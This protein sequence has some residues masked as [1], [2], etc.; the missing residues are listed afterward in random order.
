MGCTQ[1]QPQAPVYGASELSAV[2]ADIPGKNEEAAR[3]KYDEGMKFGFETTMLHS[4]HKLDTDNRARAPP[5]F[6]TTSFE[7]KD[8]G[9]G[10][11]LFA[12]AEL[13]P[14]YT[15]LMNPTSHVLEYKI[16]ELEGAPC[17]AHGDWDN[18]TTLPSA[19]AVA[20]GQSAQMTALLTIMQN[21]DNFVS[22][23]E[24]YGGT[25]TQF[26]YSFKNVGIDA[27]FADVSDHADIRSKI[28]ANTKAIYIE[29]L[30]NPSG[31]VP[32]FA[33]IAAIA[34]E[35]KV[36]LICD[37]TFGMG[38]YTCKP[39]KLGCDVVVESATKWIGGHGTSIGGIV[40]DGSSF[41]WKV[42]N[43][44]GSLKFPLVG[45]PQEAYHGG[46]FADHPVFGV[47]ATNT[48]FILL[49]RVKT[50][51]DMGGCQ[52]PFNSFQLIQGLETL[53][54]RARA[55]SDNANRLAAWLSAHP[56]VKP[57]SVQH[58]SLPSHPSHAR[59][60]QFFRDGCFGAVFTF[61]LAGGKAQGEKFIS[62]TELC[63]NLANVG[64]ARTLVIQPSATTHQQLSAEQQA[65][66]GVQPG[67]I[68]VSVGYESFKDIQAD[69][70]QA[71][72]KAQQR[73]GRNIKRRTSL[74]M[75]KKEDQM[76]ITAFVREPR[77][78]VYE[79]VLYGPEILLLGPGGGSGARI[80]R[81]RRSGRTLSTHKSKKNK[82]RKQRQKKKDGYSYLKSQSKHQKKTKTKTKKKKKKKKKKEAKKPH[83][84]GARKRRRH[85]R[86][87][88][89]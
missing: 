20:S 5:I 70:D 80:G 11:Q 18:A 12:L 61:E 75:V 81:G 22:A 29:T 48:V 34:R 66:A 2:L 52:S 50:L 88:D 85:G 33:A 56:A 31:T 24:L 28:D 1:S 65:A 43:E 76:G 46:Q 39:L 8:N 87:D 32:D 78:C 47:E 89:L 59:A 45:G 72:A 14:I 27:R 79:V 57:G 15:R 7:F 64:D 9:H 26:A 69:F 41:N 51:R 6:Q 21:G 58:P 82:K 60:K 49:A 67:S 19:L 73:I 40:V 3:A 71:F 37:N 30:A 10:A 23:T 53:S 42:K 38:G 44:D 62:A 74:T 17:A 83:K 25:Y 35:V 55:H 86:H 77:K 16:A 36:P 13:G 4:G 84:T 54:L 63:A 68:R